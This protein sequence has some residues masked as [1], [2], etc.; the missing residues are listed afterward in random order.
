VILVV[1]GIATAIEINVIRTNKGRYHLEEFK[2]KYGTIIVGLNENSI[3]GRYWNP[4]N[5]LRWALTIVVMVFLNRHSFAQI[6]VLLILSV[7]F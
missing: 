5:L 3:I 2:F 7:I 1:I 6:F 4:L